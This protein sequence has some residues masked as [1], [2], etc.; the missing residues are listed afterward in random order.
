MYELCL[1]NFWKLTSR[2]N[3]GFFVLF[4]LF[5]FFYKGQEPVAW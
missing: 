3:W 5:F 2:H 4:L 1:G